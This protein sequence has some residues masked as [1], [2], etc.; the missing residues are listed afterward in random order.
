MYSYAGLASS[1]FLCDPNHKIAAVF[2]TAVLT[3][4]PLIYLRH[5]YLNLK[6]GTHLNDVRR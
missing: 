5:L 4:L 3:A 6:L 2:V 1:I